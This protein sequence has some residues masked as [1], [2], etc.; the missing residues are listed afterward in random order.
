MMTIEEFCDLH[1]ACDEGREWALANCKDM[2]EV[3]DKAKPE[4]LVWV[5]TREKV[6]DDRT[7]RLFA[8]FCARQVWHLLR[9]ERSRNAVVVAERHA[10]GLATDEEL[11]AAWTA[12]GT[13][14]W[15][16]AGTAAWEAA[17]TAAGTAARAAAWTAA[18]AAA[19]AAAWDAAW[20]A[21]R[22]A[23]W[24]AAWAA[25][26]DDQAAWLRANAKPCFEGGE[27]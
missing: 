22:A 23:A 8:C 12:A 4:W 7:L 6:L 27:G 19:R 9:D 18:R 25:A 13:A 16:A 5:A 26:G 10:D 1:E 11:K 15:T 21:A 17:G 24:D 2:Q 20:A 14:A 3:W